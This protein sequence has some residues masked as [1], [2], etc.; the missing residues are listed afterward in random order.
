[1]K[2]IIIILLIFTTVKLYGQDTVK[3]YWSN[4]QLMSIGVKSGGIEHGKWTYYHKNGK[5]WSEGSFQYGRKVGHWMMWYEDGQVSQDYYADNGAFK[6][7]YKSG[8][9][10]A[11]GQFKDGKRTGIWT[12]QHP[13]GKLF[14]KCEFV[15]DSING[16]VT[17]YHDNGQKAF[18][19]TYKNG[20]LNG[21]SHWW[22]PDGLPEMEGKSINDWV[23]RSGK[24]LHL[25]LKDMFIKVKEE[26]VES[27]S[28]GKYF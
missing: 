19:G 2:K 18:E 27:K 22:T 12:F 17:E 6:S 20:K 24:K 25:E 10:E 8:A 4:N 7:Y 26:G 16:D 11:T 21:Y 3:E 9:V 13:N 28:N 15:N 23:D 5:K 14:K 1:M